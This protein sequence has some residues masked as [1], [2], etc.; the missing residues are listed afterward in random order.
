[1]DDYVIKNEALRDR[2]EQQ[3]G[4]LA[5]LVM[6]VLKDM[7]KPRPWEKVAELAV[8]EYER[9]RDRFLDD[10]SVSDLLI[11]SD[12]WVNKKRI[13]GKWGKRRIEAAIIASGWYLA[14]P[15]GEGILLTKERVVIEQD[16]TKDFRALKSR[17]ERMSHRNVTIHE[18]TGA[19]VKVA[20]IQFL[21]LSNVS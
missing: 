21:P 16:A 9:N 4:F 1:M 18:K 12:D 7:K 13:L 5:D 14:K 8:F 15:P 2:R 20:T 10:P 3:S 17:A 6:R 11:P 19:D